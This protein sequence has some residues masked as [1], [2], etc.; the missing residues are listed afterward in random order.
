MSDPAKREW[1]FY[2]EDMIAFADKVVAYTDGLDQGGFVSCGLN[3]DAT[4]P[5][6]L[7][8]LHKLNAAKRR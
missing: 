5:G 4:V 6:L 1:R 8:A 3:Y 2:L 7:Q